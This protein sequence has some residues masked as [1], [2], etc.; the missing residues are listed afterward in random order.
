MSEV[1]YFLVKE[2]ALL[3]PELE[4][5]LSELSEQFG[6][7]RRLMFEPAAIQDHVVQVHEM[8]S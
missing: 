2:L 1:L 8:D 3:Q 4:T 5:G 7:L 6:K